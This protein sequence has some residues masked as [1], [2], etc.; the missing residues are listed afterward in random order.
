M[1]NVIHYFVSNKVKSSLQLA[2]L[3]AVQTMPL[4][5]SDLFL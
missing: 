2:L 5:L 1:Y 3:S 4:D